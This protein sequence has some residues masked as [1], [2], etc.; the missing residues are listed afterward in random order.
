MLLRNKK[1][2]FCF[3][4]FFVTFFFL[5]TKNVFSATININPKNGEY[6]VGDTLKIK[7]YIES[8]TSANAVSASLKFS[9]DI[10]SLSSISKNG[11]I[12]DLWAKE[13]IYSN[14]DGSFSFEGVSLN[15]FIGNSG[16]ILTLNFKAKKEGTGTI[17]F[18]DYSILANDG[19]GTRV[20]KGSSNFSFTINKA[21][22]ITPK[23]EE[24]KET[25][26]NIGITENPKETILKIIEIERSNNLPRYTLVILIEILIILIL[27]IVIFYLNHFYNKIKSSVKSKLDEVEQD[28][29]NSVKDEE[30]EKRILKEIEEIEKEL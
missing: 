23:K 25:V 28:I 22:T 14:A 13:P 27:I 11:S 20:D 21:S 30:S 15:G 7:I 29:E 24:K 5:N 3:V 26:D 9:K 18:I 12:I 6:Q 8:E 10:I 1:L 4:L 19:L 16:T 17:D 2:I